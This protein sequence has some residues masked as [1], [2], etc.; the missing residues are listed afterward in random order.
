MTHIKRLH[1]ADCL[2]VLQAY[3]SQSI[4][5][6]ITDPPYGVGRDKGFAGK[7]AFG[8]GNGKAIERKRYVGEW[9]NSRPEKIYFDEMLRVAK[10]VLIFGGNYFTDYLPVSTHWLV[11]DKAQTMPSFGDCELIW[12]NID[13][14]SVKWIKREW[15]GL[16]GKEKKRFH[17]TQK[18]E[19]I[20]M[21]LVQNYTGKNDLVC[22]PF[23]GSGT[24]G[25]ACMNLGRY[26][27]GIERDDHYFEIA[28]RRVRQAD[29]QLI[30]DL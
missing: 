16:L 9:D 7:A 24:T 15:N 17:A 8:G 18:P 29:S 12:T 20:M 28:D 25:V 22:D 11:W 23:M 5:V 3:A 10:K 6:I 4:D 26:F 30:M 19:S 27:I 21:W 13:R 1:H 2:P 14:K